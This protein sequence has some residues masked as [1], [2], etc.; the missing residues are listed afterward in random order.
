MKNYFYLSIYTIRRKQNLWHSK[1][2]I[3][4]EKLKVFA[5]L[6]CSVQSPS[7]ASLPRVLSGTSM[8]K[9]ANVSM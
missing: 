6:H 8:G 4:H 5:S 1:T 7:V 9:K 3:F 2:L